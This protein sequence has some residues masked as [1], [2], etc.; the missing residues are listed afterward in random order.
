MLGTFSSQSRKLQVLSFLYKYV[1]DGRRCSINRPFSRITLHLPCQQHK[2]KDKEVSRK[3][4]NTTY[5]SVPI[6]LGSWNTQGNHHQVTGSVFVF[7]S[8][9]RSLITAKVGSMAD[10]RLEKLHE[11]LCSSKQVQGNVVHLIILCTL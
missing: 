6:I 11:N 10:P 9:L 3:P 5:S 8:A 7:F 2:N 4:Y 1:K